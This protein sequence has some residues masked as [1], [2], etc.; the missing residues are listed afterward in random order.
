[1][2]NS[3]TSFSFA[4]RFHERL[5]ESLK[6]V[7]LISELSLWAR[8]KRD[9][10]RVYAQF[11]EDFE[12]DAVDASLILEASKDS[13]AIASSSVADSAPHRESFVDPEE[14]INFS[15][16]LDSWEEPTRRGKQQVSASPESF[17]VMHQMQW[18]L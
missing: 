7:L 13:E 2:A 12:E 6:E 14:L 4:V 18:L 16:I 8:R 15:K 10:K 11:L 3:S 1:M 17:S 9:Q 5:Y